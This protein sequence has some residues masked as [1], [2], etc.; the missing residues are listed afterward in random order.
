MPPTLQTAS[1]G[2]IPAL[3]GLRAVAILLVV[4]SHAGLVMLPGAFGVTLFF[5]ISGYLITRQLLHSLVQHGRIG[6]GG[7]Y[8]RRVLRLL[9][10]GLAYILVAGLVFALV[11]GRVTGLGWLAAL[12]YG[13][14]FFDLWAGYTSSLPGVRHPFNILWSLAIEEHF[15]AVWPIVLGA[16][17][18]WR[19]AMG[20]MVLLCAAVLLWRIWLFG[21]CPSGA[22]PAVCGRLPANPAW[23]YNRL[24]LG[25]DARIDSIAWGA[26]LAMAE[27]RGSTWTVQA[28]Q[29]RTWQ[30][31][32]VLLLAASFLL[33]GAFARQVLRTSLQG[34]ALL[35][36]FPAILQHGH[37]LRRALSGRPAL[38]IGRLSYS[39]YLWHWGAFALADFVAGTSRL[40]WL[41]VGLPAAAA[42]AAASYVCIE[43]PMLRLRRRAGSH[44]PLTIPAPSGK[45]PTPLLQDAP[46][47]AT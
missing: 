7:F 5:F 45:R 3:D 11:G 23:R 37:R 32:A 24:Y 27:Q 2:Y 44:A 16:V 1:A 34:A 22:W 4:A 8:L 33:P 30:A 39:L 41:A 43:L 17:W 12:F 20:A 13:A 35:V 18:R 29:R 28:G 38:I 10:A 15:Y 36:L 42:L 47:A 9:P 46:H 14:N 6:L 19:G 21:H 25:T 26:L 40:L 31:G